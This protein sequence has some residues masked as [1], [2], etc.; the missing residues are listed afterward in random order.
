VSAQADENSHLRPERPQYAVNVIWLLR[1]FGLRIFHL[2]V[3][4]FY[5]AHHFV[6]PTYKPDWH[7]PPLNSDLLTRFNLTDI[8]GYRRTSRF[9]FG[10][11]VPGCHERDCRTDDAN[12]TY[13]SR[14][15]DKEAASTLAH[16]AIIH[17]GFLPSGDVTARKK[18][19]SVHRKGLH[20]PKL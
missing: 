16:V 19:D 5:V 7:T 11:G 20:N 1:G 13:R 12:S 14:S 3:E 2:I 4:L 8:D 15:T 10:T 6:G 18:A 9:R 17:Y